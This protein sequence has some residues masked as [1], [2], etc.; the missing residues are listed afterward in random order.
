MKKIGI[1]DSGVGG[2][3][4]LKLLINQKYSS[5][6]YYLSDEKNVPY[7]GRAQSFML[8]RVRLMV[9]KLLSEKVD[10]IVLACNT[11]TAETIDIL[12]SENKIPLFGIEPYINYL[13]KNDSKNSKCALILTEA[14][15]K[16]KRFQTLVSEKDKNHLIDIYPLKNLALLVESLKIENTKKIRESILEELLPLKDKGYTHLILGCTHYPIIWKTIES[17]LNLKTI[18]PSSNVISHMEKKLSLEHDLG[19]SNKFYY[20][21]DLSDHFQEVSMDQ[22]KFFD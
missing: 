9:A 7:G 8:E 1:I 16:S 20:N 4:L 22:F 19:I 21:P 5:T 11:L 3:S 14:T 2:L 12:R 10:A 13:N 18:D 6:Y 15:F 17:F